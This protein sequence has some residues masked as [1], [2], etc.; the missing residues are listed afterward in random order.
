MW[1]IEHENLSGGKREW[2]KPGSQR[3]YGRTRLGDK[4][5]QAHGKNVFLDNKTISR[6]HMMLKVLD[7][8]PQDGVYWE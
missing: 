8:S 6:K 7:V 4:E 3:L 1:F 5:D 2:I